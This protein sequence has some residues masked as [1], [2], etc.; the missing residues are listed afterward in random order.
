MRLQGSPRFLHG[1]TQEQP[2]L[3]TEGEVFA[4]R[5]LLPQ[6]SEYDFNVHVRGQRAAVKGGGE[7]LRWA[8]HITYPFPSPGVNNA[9]P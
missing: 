2:L 4:L 8:A 7:P 6:S 5:K 1:H 3:P 9:A